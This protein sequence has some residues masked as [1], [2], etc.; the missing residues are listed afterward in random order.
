MLLVGLKLDE[1]VS[2]DV[3]GHGTC[4]V[5]VT[6]VRR[7][8]VRLGITA[9]REW[10]IVRDEVAAREQAQQEVSYATKCQDGGD[11]QSG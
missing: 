9:P 4:H 10:P 3:P 5:L 6:R 7:G 1:G 11:G 2:I 8:E